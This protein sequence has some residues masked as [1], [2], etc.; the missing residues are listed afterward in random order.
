MAPA[1]I[2]QPRRE[3]ARRAGAGFE[4]ALF[5]DAADNSTSVEIWHAAS[6]ETLRYVV[7]P[8]HALDAYYHPFAHLRMAAAA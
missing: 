7:P 6:H 3:L 8:E 1:T 4:V 5:W 2:F